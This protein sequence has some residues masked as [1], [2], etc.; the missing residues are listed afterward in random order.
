MLLKKINSGKEERLAEGSYKNISED[1]GRVHITMTD[2]LISVSVDVTEIINKEEPS[3]RLSGGFGF[4][5]NGVAASVDN[6]EI[7]RYSDKEY[8]SKETKAAARKVYVSPDGSDTYG[9]GTKEKPF[10]SFKKVQEAVKRLVSQNYPVDVIFREGTY[11]LSES[12]SFDA[13]YTGTASAPIRYMAEP[14]E[15]VVFSGG[16]KIDTASFKP[17]STDIKER[18]FPNV[19]D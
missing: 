8:V 1:T 9:D 6:L 16:T 18:L 17:V 15:K 14:G 7:Y 5:A 3:L 19:A 11:Y 13:K 10:A 2:T 12:I 4:E